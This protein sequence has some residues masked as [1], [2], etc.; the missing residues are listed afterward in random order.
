MVAVVAVVSGL[1]GFGLG[2]GFVAG[3]AEGLEVGGVVGASLAEG[4]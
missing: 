4:G 1:V 2:F 3:G